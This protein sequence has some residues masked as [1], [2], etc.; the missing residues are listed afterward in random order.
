MANNNNFVSNKDKRKQ[1]LAE[2]KRRAAYKSPSKTAWGKILIIILI[3]GMTIG[4]SL[5]FF[6]FYLINNR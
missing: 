3:L 5:I 6:I 1:E 2:E 4:S